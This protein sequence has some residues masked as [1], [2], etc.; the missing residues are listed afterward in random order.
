MA[1]HD[2]VKEKEPRHSGRIRQI[3]LYLGKL[4]R[5]F[6]YMDDW[7]VIPMAALVAGLVSLV[8]ASKIFRSMEGTLA[9]ALALTCLCIWN[10]FFNSI[11][12]VCRERDVVKRE[13]RNGMHISSYIIAH[14]IYQ[15]FIC[16]VQV[17]VTIFVCDMGGMAFP[18]E[19][20]ITSSFYVDLGITLFLITYASDMLSLLISCFAK[21]TTSAMT[22]MP[23][24]LIFE[25]LFSDAMF[26]LSEALEPFTNLSFAKW[27]IRCITTLADYNSQPMTSVWS[28]LVKLKGV[29]LNGTKPVELFVD[30]IQKNGLKDQFNL[31]VGQHTQ[32]AEYARNLMN[33]FNCW[34][35]LILFA[36]ICA[37]FAIIILEFIDK[38]KR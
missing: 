4:F 36:F 29:E 6:F 23:F 37:V 30:Y 18:T 7:K 22:I 28:Q 35:V 38:D 5:L 34:L 12:S 1:Q 11:Q 25:L 33:I 27:G 24:M 8:S 19:G 3:P 10:G 31:M 26:K 32:N 13:H 21:N 16:A 15:A 2:K 14:M 17:V 9:G 20:F